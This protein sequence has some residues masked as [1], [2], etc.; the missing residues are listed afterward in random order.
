[1]HRST[2]REEDLA[3]P[4]ARIE[5]ERYVALM[6]HAKAMTA[7]DA[8]ALHLGEQGELAE[9]S[10]VGALRP[11]SGRP[12][13][14]LSQTN[15]YVPLLI[16]VPISG[17]TRF[18]LKDRTDGLWVVDTRS[19]PNSFPELT[20]SAFARTISTFRRHGAADAIRE[21]R[22]TH[23]A[24]E[25]RDEYDRVFQVPTTFDCER[26]EL[27]LDRSILERIHEA[28]TYANSVLQE[29]AEA[30]L[31]ELNRSHSTRTRVERILIRQIAESSA[32]VDA[33]ARALGF[34][35][36]TLH[37]RLKEEGATFERVRDNLRKELALRTLARETISTGQLAA[38]LGFSDRSAFARAFKRWTGKGPATWKRSASA[39]V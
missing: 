8:L 35:R 39:K 3:D 17:A 7:D 18:E 28:P 9:F 30:L 2:I 14:G 33:V 26:N 29:H 37:R 12:L 34:S 25:H 11:T 6:R 23:S 22:V 20:E 5:L 4:D 1:M 19:D 32:N 27:R 10:V 13:D 21:V 38:V 15:R 24:P 16:D 31:S 36:Q